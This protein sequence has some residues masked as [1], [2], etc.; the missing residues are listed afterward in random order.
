MSDIFDGM[1]QI[2]TQRFH[3]AEE[4]LTPDASLDD[5]GMDSLD[6]VEF[7]LMLEQAH[8]IRFGSDVD[9]V[10][11]LAQTAALIARKKGAVE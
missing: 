6:R 11:T 1:R 9:G 2:L 3:A 10:R 8:G 5:L 7:A 4:Q